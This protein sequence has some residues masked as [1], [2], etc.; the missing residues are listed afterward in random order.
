MP[1]QLMK[2]NIS[3][4]A[5]VFIVV[6]HGT[7]VSAVFKNCVQELCS[8]PAEYSH[9][10]KGCWSGRRTELRSIREAFKEKVTK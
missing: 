9:F 5:G 3:G 4:K 2:G 6:H 1:G 10:S 8:V 7:F